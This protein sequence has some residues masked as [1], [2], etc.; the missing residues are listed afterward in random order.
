MSDLAKLSSVEISDTLHSYKFS[1][2]EINFITLKIA[3]PTMTAKEIGEELGLQA[4][5]INYYNRNPYVIEV[6]EKL[7][8]AIIE[9]VVASK[10]EL[11]QQRLNEFLNLTIWD[12][13]NKKIFN[14][15]KFRAVAKAIE[16]SIGI[17]KQ[18]SNIKQQNN[19]QINNSYY[20]DVTI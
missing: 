15:D 17:E 4:A 6:L 19:L 5:T 11:I 13:E 3:N 20:Q 10:T 1:I 16:L 14:Y 18:N 2:N 12:D 9:K 8:I 7:N